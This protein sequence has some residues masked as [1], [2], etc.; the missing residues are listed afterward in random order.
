MRSIRPVARAKPF[1]GSAIGESTII[2]LDLTANLTSLD[3]GDTLMG[4]PA[5]PP[6]VVL[7]NEP[8][9][10]RV[11]AAL[12]IGVVDYLT[13][14]DGENEIVDRLTTQL[15]KAQASTSRANASRAE[16]PA[17]QRE[18]ANGSATSVLPGLDLNA[19]AAHAH[20]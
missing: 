11:V 5:C 18:S 3:L 1:R 16:A 19:G 2:L 15:A 14:S 12:R 9:I 13:V 4:L 8:L 7:D 17:R 10:E 6:I 20:H